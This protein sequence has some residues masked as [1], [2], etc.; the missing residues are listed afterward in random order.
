SNDKLP[1]YEKEDVQSATPD[2]AQKSKAA[3]RVQDDTSLGLSGS[4][5]EPWEKPMRDSWDIMMKTMRLGDFHSDPLKQAINRIVNQTEED[6]SNLPGNRALVLDVLAE[7]QGIIQQLFQHTGDLEYL[8]FHIRCCTRAL[9]LGLLS[10][11]NTIGWLNNLGISFWTRSRHLGQSSDLDAALDHFIRAIGLLPQDS[12]LLPGILQNI[13]NCYLQRF[14]YR[15]ATED[16]NLALENHQ[17]AMSLTL[18]E[19]PEMANILNGFSV[20]LQQRYDILGD[21]QDLDHA[22][23][24]QKKS[25]ALTK[26][27]D[28]DM[29]GRL[30]NLGVSYKAR[31]QRLGEVDDINNAIESFS[32]AF[33]LTPRN[34]PTAVSLHKNLADSY[35]FR[36]ARL[37]DLDDVNKAVELHN[38]VVAATPRNHPNL[39]GRFI[40]LGASHTT[41][42][43][44]LG[45]DDDLSAA[46]EAHRQAL[47]LTPDNQPQRPQYKYLLTAAISY[48]MRFNSHGIIEDIDSSISYLHE[49]LALTSGGHILRPGLLDT[50][51]GAYFRRHSRLHKLKDLDESINWHEQAVALSTDSVGNLPVYLAN[52]GA[53]YASRFDI[54]GD[55]KDMDKAI[56]CGL[57]ALNLLPEQHAST[58]SLLGN[59]GS[60]YGIRFRRSQQQTDIDGAIDYLTKALSLVPEG[61][62]TKPSILNDLAI[63]YLER[64][65]YQNQLDDLELAI[66]FQLSSISL[67]PKEHPTVPVLLNALGGLYLRHHEHQHD[68]TSLEKSFE[69]FRDSAQHPT[70]DPYLKFRSAFAWAQFAS[71]KSRSQYEQMNAY[72]TAMGL[73][74]QMLTLAAARIDEQFSELRK[75]GDLAVAATAVAIATEDYD[76]AIE[77]LEQ[78]RSMVWNHMLQLQVPLDQL[79]SVS[80]TLASRLQELSRELHQ[81]T[82]RKSKAFD[83]ALHPLTPEQSAQRHRRISEEYGRLVNQTR[84]IP[85]FERFLELPKSSDLIHAARGGPLV[86][87]NVDKLRCDALAITSDHKTKLHIPLPNLTYRKVKDSQDKMRI[88]LQKQGIRSRHIFMESDSESLEQDELAEVLAFLWRDLVEPILEAL[89]LSPRSGADDLPHITWCATGAL[90]FLPIHAAGDYE[91]HDSKLFNYAISSYT[92]TLSAL[93]VSSYG[94]HATPIKKGILAI[95]QAHSKAWVY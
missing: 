14:Q 17:K 5:N 7:L 31:F 94:P 44:R 57:R 36:Y 56:D 76:Q 68:D 62:V 24:Y 81:A 55:L 69:S 49:A 47:L 73:V 92:P 70:G 21:E 11:A 34:H 71:T 88:S 2:D 63:S 20:I 18:N 66:K 65:D 22:L 19:T 39:L 12:H 33:N 50:L 59:L 45:N 79:Y 23:E 26:L 42:Y 89:K 3:E 93:L 8:S 60:A 46:I 72:R 1:R 15:G 87:V 43:Q 61:G 53:S 38:Q 27:G 51:G 77:W 25:V 86:I 48:Q 16:L 9:D 83:E 30:G 4:D 90:S 74:P 82:L 64:Y 52:L 41:R 75:V 40:S 6:K 13:G 54:Q 10:D 35:H 37:G 67:A 84:R 85:G 91:H 28:H 78:G 95:G 80:P 29:P 32:K 58:S